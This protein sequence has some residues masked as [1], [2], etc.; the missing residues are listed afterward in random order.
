MRRILTLSYKVLAAASKLTA[1]GNPGI[2]P[3]GGKMRKTAAAAF[4]LL[5]GIT[6]GYCQTAVLVTDEPELQV[7]RPTL[8]K[9]IGLAGAEAATLTAIARDCGAKQA[10]TIDFFPMIGSPTLLPRHK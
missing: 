7:T 10:P 8:Q 5:A 1:A 9:A 6:G 4:F 3:T 2:L